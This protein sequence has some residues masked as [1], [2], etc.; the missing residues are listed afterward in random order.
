MPQRHPVTTLASLPP[1]ASRAFTIAGQRIAL[2]NVGGTIHAMEDTCPH[3]GA[4]PV[5]GPARRLRRHLPVARHLLR[6]LHG[7]R[8]RPGRPRAGHVPGHRHRRPDRDRTLSSAR[9]LATACPAPECSRRWE[10]ARSRPTGS[11][12]R[13]QARSHLGRGVISEW[14]G[15]NSAGPAGRLSAARPSSLRRR[16]RRNSALPR[17]TRCRPCGS[18]AGSRR[19]SGGRRRRHSDR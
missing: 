3:A 15:L 17:R 8:A 19:R 9:S 18:A 12:S 4:P 11:S 7:L 13:E 6:R 5:R 10:R 14:R 1:G 16:G 2:F